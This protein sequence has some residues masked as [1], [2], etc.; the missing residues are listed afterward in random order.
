MYTCGAVAAASMENDPDCSMTVGVTQ[1]SRILLHASRSGG[2]RCVPSNPLL[3]AISEYDPKPW[4]YPGPSRSYWSGRP[5][6]KMP[7][8]QYSI[9]STFS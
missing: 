2:Y 4:P 8:Y 1:P 6:R 5:G 9:Y 7:Q 3:L